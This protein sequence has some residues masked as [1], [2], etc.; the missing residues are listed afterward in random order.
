MKRQQRHRGRTGPFKSRSH[1]AWY[2][3]WKFNR[4]LDYEQGQDVQADPAEAIRLMTE[5][6]E[7]G[8]REALLHLG[9]CFLNGVGVAMD[10]DQARFWYRK[11]ARRGEPRAMYSLADIEIEAHNFELA[12]EWLRGAIATNYADA[13]FLLGKLYW[14]GWGVPQDR[15]QAMVLFTEAARAKVPEAQRVLRFFEYRIKRARQR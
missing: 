12:T 15:K 10:L 7:K 5:A 6:A 9:W 14:R 13:R 4:A 8:N 1:D 11:S 2:P 3:R